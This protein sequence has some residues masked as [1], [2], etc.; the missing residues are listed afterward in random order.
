MIQVGSDTPQNIT[1]PTLQHK[2]GQQHMSERTHV[3]RCASVIFTIMS[4]QYNLCDFKQK[5]MLR[6][7]PETESERERAGFVMIMMRITMMMGIGKM[8]SLVMS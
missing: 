6:R 7:E 8:I 1:H 3:P 2:E 4:Q 5:Y